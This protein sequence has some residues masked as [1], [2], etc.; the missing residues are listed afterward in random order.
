MSG[1]L[2]EG[3]SLSLGRIFV[4]KEIRAAAEYAGRRVP[5]IYYKSSKGSPV[6][7]IWSGVPIK[8]SVSPKSQ[9]AYAL[10]AA[11]K[12]LKAKTGLLAWAHDG[13]E[14]HARGISHVPW[15]YWS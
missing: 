11:M 2:G 7:L 1:T 5:P 10:S 14:L 15:T 9:V 3:R 13:T 6:D 8:V 12:K 4:L